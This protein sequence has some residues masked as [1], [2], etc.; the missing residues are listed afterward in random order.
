MRSFREIENGLIYNVFKPSL[1]GTAIAHSYNSP[2]DASGSAKYIIPSHSPRGSGA[3]SVDL[4]LDEIYFVDG[5]SEDP[6][7]IITNVALAACV[8]LS[9]GWMSSCSTEHTETTTREVDTAP[10]PV[11]VVV[12]AAPVVT[13]PAVTVPPN[14]TTS[15][16]T[17][18]FNNGTVEKKT[19]T[20]YNSEYPPPVVYSAPPVVTTVPETTTRTTTS[21]DGV[22]Q[23][24]T[25]TTYVA[26]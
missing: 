22:V 11:P 6:M 8:G 7:K 15:S 21:D 10:A 12:T 4:S 3:N 14:A 16:T 19:V 18:H 2:E 13:E 20:Q 5:Q 1:G 23:R 17:T 9:L 26:P 24:Q 25:T